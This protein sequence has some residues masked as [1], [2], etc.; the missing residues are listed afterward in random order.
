MLL[1]E[2]TACDI[3]MLGRPLFPQLAVANSL[4]PT[5]SLD[6]QFIDPARSALRRTRQ[7]RFCY[8]A[9]WYDD[10]ELRVSDGDGLACLARHV[11]SR[12]LTVSEFAWLLCL[13]LERVL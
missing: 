10:D 13:L 2:I 1:L 12:I 7:C 9:Q 5:S 4:L 8:D 3:L 11:I 6:S